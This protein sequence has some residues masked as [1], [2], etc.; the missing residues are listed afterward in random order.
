MKKDTTI[1]LSKDTVICLNGE[2]FRVVLKMS[3]AY[4]YYYNA[5]YVHTE[6]LIPNLRTQITLLNEVLEIEEYQKE[7]NKAISTGD[8]A[9][10][11]QARDNY[12][13]KAKDFKKIKRQ[14]IFYKTLSIA[15]AV[16][17]TGLTGYIVISKL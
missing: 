15:E 1:Y 14:L 4:D 12:T 10:I 2:E 3:N 9:L 17:I 8:Q 13:K 6:K 7:I 16:V 5:Y 11:A